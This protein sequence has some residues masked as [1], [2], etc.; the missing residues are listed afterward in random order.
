[1]LLAGTPAGRALS[2]FYYLGANEVTP[3]VVGVVH[4]K[5]SADEFSTLCACSYAMPVW[6][7]VVVEKFLNPLKTM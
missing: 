6:M 1:M 5:L 2:A 4:S 3:E 7:R